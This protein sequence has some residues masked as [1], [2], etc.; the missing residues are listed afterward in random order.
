[1]SF[2]DFLKNIFRPSSFSATSKK[3][4]QEKWQ[5]IEELMQLGGE[6]HFRQAVIFADNLTDKVIKSK[7]RGETMGERLKKS[8]KLFNWQT[9]DGLWKAHKIRNEIVHNNDHELMAHEARMAIS[10]FERALRE[11]KAL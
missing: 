6:S 11:L 1:M 10:R 9:Y 4:I 3:E 2:I 7:V 8:Q 5:K